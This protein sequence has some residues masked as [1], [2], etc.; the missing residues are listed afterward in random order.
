M[1]C[2]NF[3]K[4]LWNLWPIFHQVHVTPEDRH[5]LHFLWF[6][7]NSTSQPLQVF[8][9]TVHILGG[10]WSPRCA[11]YALQKVIEEY[12]N[13]YSEVV[14]AVLCKVYEDDCLNSINSVES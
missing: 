11:S 10:V 3:D 13:M 4:E 6:E 2:Y 5:S 1:F 12:C 14:N 8:R 9:M 7:N